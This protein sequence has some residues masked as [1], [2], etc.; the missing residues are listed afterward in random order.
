MARQATKRAKGK[1]S[2]ARSK[3][4]AGTAGKPAARSTAAGK[5][6]LELVMRRLLDA[7]RN[8][9]FRAWTE[10]ERL[11]RWWGPQGFTIPHCRMDVREGGSWRTCMRSP[12]GKDHWVQGRYEEIDPPSRLAFSWAWEGDD[13]EPGHET[14]V[15]ISLREQG[16]K[17]MMTMRQRVFESIKSRDSHQ[18]GWN[19]TFDKLAAYLRAK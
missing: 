3:R 11:T 7:P 2:A 9:V 6:G 14:S 1:A 16:G 13:G 18:W 15:V 8:L 4:G 19:S 10:P 12:E 5:K 17:T